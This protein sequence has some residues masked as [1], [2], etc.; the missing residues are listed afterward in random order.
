MT[1]ECLNDKTAAAVGAF[2]IDHQGWEAFCK[3]YLK[4]WFLTEF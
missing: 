1:F 4:F 3:E 2:V